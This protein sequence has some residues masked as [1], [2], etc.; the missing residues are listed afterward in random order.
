MILLRSQPGLLVVGI[1]VGMVPQTEAPLEPQL[2]GIEQNPYK[3]IPRVTCSVWERATS[4]G[5]RRSISSSITCKSRLALIL[6]GL[7][8]SSGGGWRGV[9]RHREVGC[10][11]SVSEA[12]VAVR[13]APAHSSPTCLYPATDQ[14]TDSQNACHN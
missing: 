3:A 6:N 7:S 4:A 11:H 2:A 5:Y 14:N 9:R 10:Q 8:G 13:E 12:G 1:A